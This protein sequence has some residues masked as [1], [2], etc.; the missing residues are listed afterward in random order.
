MGKL[1]PK[2][3]AIEE[4]LRKIRHEDGFVEGE[5][6]LIGR[7]HKEIG[8]IEKSVVASLLQEIGETHVNHQ[9]VTYSKTV[10]WNILTKKLLGEEQ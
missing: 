5:L 1:T 8:I 4:K 6:Y 2:L 7:L 10:I 3:D 9:G